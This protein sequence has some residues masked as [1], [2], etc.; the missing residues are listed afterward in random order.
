MP[1]LSLL[2]RHTAL[3]D[4]GVGSGTGVGSAIAVGAG[5]WEGSGVEESAGSGSVRPG[6][7][8]AKPLRCWAADRGSSRRWL[9]GKRR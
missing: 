9:A 3:V 8:P 6:R 4:R 7:P 2:S 5:V 1:A